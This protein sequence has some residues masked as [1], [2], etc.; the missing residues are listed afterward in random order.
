MI[1]ASIVSN[2]GCGLLAAF[3]LLAIPSIGHYMDP[4]NAV[5]FPDVA[6]A[7]TVGECYDLLNA[8]WKAAPQAKQG[9]AK[10]LMAFFALVARIEAA[11]LMALGIGAV[12][13]MTLK[14]EQRHPALF[15]LG[16]A[17][18][19]ASGV[20]LSSAGLPIGHNG[21]VTEKAK[22]GGLALAGLWLTAGTCIWIGFFASRA[23]AGK[24]KAA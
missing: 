21:M 8:A 18:I 24:A 13:T 16:C 14:L 19:L 9:V 1:S 12:Y 2:V 3:F 22:A 15:I 20:D 5:N 11:V 6:G 4:C 17:S 10:E 23:A 7:L